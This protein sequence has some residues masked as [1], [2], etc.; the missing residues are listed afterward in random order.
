MGSDGEQCTAMKWYA[1]N[2]GVQCQ[3]DM[4][5]VMDTDTEDH[6]FGEDE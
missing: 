3:L 6:D 4:Q 2:Y 1:E 5:H